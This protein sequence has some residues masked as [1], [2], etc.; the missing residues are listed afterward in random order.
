MSWDGMWSTFDADGTDW[1]YDLNESHMSE[2]LRY[3]VRSERSNAHQFVD[4]AF[5]SNDREDLTAIELKSFVEEKHGELDE[6]MLAELV[7]LR[8]LEDELVLE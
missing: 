4:F 8:K 6:E 2:D 7:E 3:I 5:E 1:E